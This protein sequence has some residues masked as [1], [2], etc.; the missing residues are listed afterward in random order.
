MTLRGGCRPTKAYGTRV[1]RADDT[2]GRGSARV[3]EQRNDRRAHGQQPQREPGREPGTWERVDSGA[4]GAARVAGGGLDGYLLFSPVRGVQRVEA[5]LTADDARFATNADRPTPA[6]S[7][8]TA[9]LGLELSRVVFN[10]LRN[11]GLFRP[12]G[13]D[14]L[15]RPSYAQ[16]TAP[17]W[18]NWSGRSN[19]SS[20]CP[21]GAASTSSSEW[22]SCAV[23]MSERWTMSDDDIE[24][25]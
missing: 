17:A 15:P 24:P 13:P 16:I 8:G 7:Q 21:I 20:G 25:V 19:A 11:N 18:G 5:D 23:R 12:V 4:Q 3:E 1:A 10:D 9:A 22:I 2:P 14:S 6:N